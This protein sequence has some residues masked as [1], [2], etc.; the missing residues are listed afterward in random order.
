ML[1]VQHLIELLPAFASIQAHR[2]RHV[3]HAFTKGLSLISGIAV[4]HSGL[5]FEEG[6]HLL[7]RAP[8]VLEQ[9]LAE[10]LMLTERFLPQQD[11]FTV[12]CRLRFQSL[13]TRRA[14]LA[15]ITHPHE[16][17]LRRT[18]TLA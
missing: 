17:V 15:G 12:S 3:R 5:P 14:L 9:P 8:S 13:H 4:A 1:L 18:A 6:T 11:R 7:L 16:T 10:R 2:D